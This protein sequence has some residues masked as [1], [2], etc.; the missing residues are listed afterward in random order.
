MEFFHNWPKKLIGA[1]HR[2]PATRCRA[3]AATQA[4]QA[5]KMR[6]SSPAV[7][8]R[9]KSGNLAPGA[10]ALIT[11][12]ASCAPAFADDLT[13]KVVN[14]TNQKPVSGDEVILFGLPNKRMQ[15]M[16]R[17]R[18]DRHGRFAVLV[19]DSH[20]THL[21]RVVHQGVTYDH[22]VQSGART[23]AV[24][25]YDVASK[26]E[27]VNAIMDVERFEATHDRLEIKQL[28]TMRNSSRPPRTLMNDRP[29][30]FRL[31]PEAEVKSGVVQVE[32]ARPIRTKPAP[33]RDKGE[34]YFP[35]PLRPG[36]TR[37]G[38]VY[39]LAYDGGAV[40]EPQIR[41][42]GERFMIMVPKSMTFQPKAPGIFQPRT[43]VSPDN[44]QEAAPV[45][46]GQMLAFRISGTGLLAEL[47]DQQQHARSGPRQLPTRPP[48]RH[49]RGSERVFRSSTSFQ[50]RDLFV[51][52]GLTVAL[53]ASTLCLYLKRRSAIARAKRGTAVHSYQWQPRRGRRR[54]SV[55]FSRTT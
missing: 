25:V 26:L 33:G 13:G 45:A 51:L 21:L 6:C 7:F 38:I 32:D 18:T 11:V 54:V 36:D 2:A 4:S 3:S 31:P 42:A 50:N 17:T 29:F 16:T 41:N 55:K 22:M 34:Y 9:V 52:S 19:A 37:F 10:L 53:T 24:D 47:H 46:V 23:V 8:V 12:L 35:Y 39:Q 30:E 40:L 49:G 15:E 48:T 14:A 1:Q 27:D 43:D 44:V 28:I 20:V 5:T